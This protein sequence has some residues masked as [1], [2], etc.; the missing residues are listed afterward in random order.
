[1]WQSSPWQHPVYIY[2]ICRFSICFTKNPRKDG[3]ST[4][5]GFY[6]HTFS[7]HI[8][9]RSWIYKD[10]A[11]NKIV[12]FFSQ[13]CVDKY[14]LKYIHTVFLMC[15]QNY[16]MVIICFIFLLTS[17]S[18]RWDCGFMRSQSSLQ[19]QTSLKQSQFSSD[20]HLH[21]YYLSIRMFR[22]RVTYRKWAHLYLGDFVLNQLECLQRMAVWAPH[23]FSVWRY[24]IHPN[25]DFKCCCSSITG[26]SNS[27]LSAQLALQW[28][29]PVK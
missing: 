17:I 27:F 6:G 25:S 23:R 9:Q 3:Q 14:I 7:L 28:A 4:G 20:L 12:Q 11:S 15:N 10:L 18:L 2:Y 1:M 24:S 5:P 16:F 19:K 21:K 29:R 22:G 8:N 13:V 26:V